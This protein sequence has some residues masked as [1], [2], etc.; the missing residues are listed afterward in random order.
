MNAAV[1]ALSSYAAYHRD[2]RN[3]LTHFIGIPLIWLAIAALISRPL[4]QPDWLPLGISPM[5]VA[6]ILLCRYYFSLHRDL[7]WVMLAVMVLTY[8]FS[9]NLA[10][11]STGTWLGVSLG[12]FAVG[13]VIQFIGHYYE[14]RKPAFFD[15]IRGLII[16]PVFVAAEACFLLGRL[17]TLQQAVEREVGPTVIKPRP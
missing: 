2:K 4:W 5:L 11:Q 1:R 16:G 7:G 10:A 13:W 6:G 12:M 9:A 3:I 14:Q 8:L 15:D 17:K